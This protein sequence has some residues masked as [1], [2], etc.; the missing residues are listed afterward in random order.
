MTPAPGERRQLFVGDRIRFSLK[1]AAGAPPP[2]GWR[3]RLRTNLGRAAQQ[4]E[5]IV[6][7]HFEKLPLAGASWRDIEMEFQASEGA[8][9]LDLPLTEVGF[10][11]GKAYAIDGNN[12]QHWPDGDDV[13]VSVNPDSCRTGS[14]IYCAFPRMFGASKARAS[15]KERHSTPEIEALDEQGYTVIPPSGK[16]RD[17]QEQLPHIIDDLGCRILLLL[18]VNSTPT[19]MARFGRYGSPYACQDLADIDPALIDFDKKSTG[20]EQFEEL[21]TAV[22]A[23]GAKVFIDLVINHTGWGS[24]LHENH[25]EW[26]KR[27]EDGEFKSPGAWG[28]VWEDLVELD[29]RFPELWD[30]LAEVFLTWC[31]RGVDG[32]RCDAG[33]KVPMHVWQYI[34]AKVRQEFPESIFLLE[35]LGGSWEATDNLL[36]H[37]GMQWAY[38]ELFQEYSGENVQRYLDHALPHSDEVG[39]LVHF[40]ETHDNLRLA[41]RGRDWSLL[42]NRL[43]ALTSVTGGFAF[44]CGVEWLAAERVNVHSSRG[45][46]WGDER[47]IIPELR[48][49]VGL[50]NDHPCFFDGARLKR[51]SRRGEAVYALGRV[52]RDGAD[53]LLVLANTDMES[54]RDLRIDADELWEGDFVDLLDSGRFG[55]ERS[56]GRV[57]FRLQ[58]GAC[59]CLAEGEGTNGLSGEDYREARAR[60]ALALQAI[61]VQTPLRQ[62]GNCDW[63]TLATM[64]DD[65]PVRF[66]AGLWAIDP[67]ALVKDCAG[68]LRRVSEK[69]QYPNVVVWTTADQNRVVVVPARHWLLVESHSTPFRARLEFA[70][71]GAPVV[72]DSIVMGGL[73]GAVFF[74][75][76]ADGDA[77]L[78]V[79]F[80]DEDATSVS[81]A[82]LCVNSVL[83]SSCDGPKAVDP[84]AIA[85]LTNGR[86]AMVRMCA[87]L[88]RV[89]SKYDCVLGANL[90]PTLPVD[91]HVLV[92]RLRA[93]LNADGFIAP[94]NADNLVSFKAGERAEWRFVAGAGDGRSVEIQLTAEMLPGRNATAIRFAR[95]E[96]STEIGA[97]LP[98]DCHVS[99]TVRF[100]IEDRS[101]HSQTKRNDG[102]EA[103]FAANSRALDDGVGFEFTPAEDRRLTVVADR[104][105]YHHEGEWSEN[106]QHFVEQTRGQEGAGDAYSPGWFEI[107]LERG[108][109]ASILASAEND[110][111]SG[112][113]LDRVA[114][115]ER[116]A[117]SGQNLSAA[118]ERAIRAFVVDRD[119]G[120]T[121]IAGY[122]W[123]LD[124]GRDTLIAA[125]G[126]LA[127][128]MKEEVAE[129]LTTFGR[130]EEN[131]TL[132]NTIHGADVSNRDTSDAPLWY[133]VVCGELA[134]SGHPIYTQ[135]VN[136]DGRTVGD[137]LLSIARKYIKGTPNGI[138]MDPES[139]LIWSPSHFTWMD[140]NYP[141]GTPREG[142]PV[143]IQ[144][145]WI[146]LLA[147]AEAIES[148]GGATGE[149]SLSDV[150]NLAE[151]SFQEL[152][153][154]ED[155]GWLTDLLIG[156]AGKPARECARDNALRSNCMLAVSF[157]FLR[158]DK[159]RRCVEAARRH[160]VVPGALRSI[161]PLPVDPPLAVIG[162][163]GQ[164]LNDPM[165]PYWGRYE[166]DE[167]TRRKPAYH[168]GTAWTWTFPAF[169]EAVAVAHALEPTESLTMNAMETSKAAVAAAR[170]YLWSMKRLLDEGCIGQ[171]PEVMD[172]D[173]PHWQRGCDAQ[174]WG[175]TEALRVWKQLGGDAPR[176]WKALGGA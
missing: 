116:T 68:E 21:A 169:C 82:L 131:G 13:G 49:L 28:V 108:G 97:E 39:A 80:H 69:E 164:P 70:D 67:A 44:T 81:G 96:P 122:P 167:D 38:S 54:E 174:A 63:T 27:G 88:G 56:G 57:H 141:A 155:K 78:G 121:V 32:F 133:G 36:T 105:E 85:L 144:A 76:G 135:T 47:N 166:G 33:Y 92:K 83:E 109:I 112:G 14:T 147:N 98:E 100:D 111:E 146:R 8:W 23:K 24:T 176:V 65:D 117:D 72:R 2:D 15:T 163:K 84:G 71:G 50:V 1:P 59:H 129:I 26:F 94:L 145:L 124:W 175:A 75:G 51:L 87:D 104:G 91:R 60:A 106:I 152:F 137:V 25:P 19:V 107:P 73:H 134:G 95:L 139:G 128:G 62:I 30:E 151:K 4:R 172:G 125:R 158:G 153:W 102:A 140:T 58:P 48:K 29:Q 130:Y 159:A 53:R 37:G 34:T 17:L 156:E 170:D 52:S 148:R 5:E 150:R 43:C 119:G 11:Q 120:K 168:N 161:A 142:Y 18:P 114:V 171:L 64:L 3:A 66:L 90:H 20:V 99:L 89:N 162:N 110:W 42:R 127:A 118:L 160:L 61:N 10:F 165:H 154:L 55:V 101:F 41:E 79:R 12:R 126:M 157:G 6:R 143:E 138:R 7:S 86:G 136:E 35:G 77:R 173:A 74:S 115:E 113:G 46:S 93:W 123:F 22:H 9:T 132:P 149:M 103:H 45:M 40:S 16:L 31:R